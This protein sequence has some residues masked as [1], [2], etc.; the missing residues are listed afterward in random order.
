MGPVELVIRAEILTGVPS[1]EADQ[2]QR[3]EIQVQR[4]ANGMGSAEGQGQ[5]KEQQ[6]ESL[7]AAWCIRQPDEATSD[8][9]AERLNRALDALLD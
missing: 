1:P 9:L 3:M 6:L 5:N 2:G 8:Q 7:V 4:L